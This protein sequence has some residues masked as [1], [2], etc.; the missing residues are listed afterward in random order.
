MGKGIKIGLI[1]TLFLLLILI[2]SFASAT[3]YDPFIEYFKNDYLTSVFPVFVMSKLFT[4][5]FFRYLL[6]TLISLAIIYLFF[7]KKQLI[8]FSIKFYLI[9][10]IILSVLY[11]I[12][13]KTSFSS[14]YLLAF[15]V[16]RML[17]HPIFLLILLPAFYYQKKT[18]TSR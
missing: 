14:G 2:R 5:L 10:F 6:N 17:I 12:L 8:I 13:L 1:V 11:F 4:N 15:Y 18:T 9:A 3:F 7:Q 16:R